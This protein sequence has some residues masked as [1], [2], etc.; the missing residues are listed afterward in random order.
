MT[1]FITHAKFVHDVESDL[2]YVEM[3]YDKYTNKKG[4]ET[5]TD[6]INTKPL[7]NWT[8]LE[9]KKRSI[10]YDKFLD[11][12]VKQ[13]IEVR[14]R[15]A[16]LKLENILSYEC[17][18]RVYVRLAHAIKIL[19]S[20]FQPPRV[21]MESAWQMELVKK[22]CKKYIPYAIQACF[23]KSRLEYFFSVLCTIEREQ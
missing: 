8:T 3:V 19:D 6:Y 2:S 23:N 5:Y 1:S 4:Y 17:D 22:V 14:Q 15:M 11:T 12:M 7:A 10:P 18:E 16:E 9:S 13:T 21:N 20:T